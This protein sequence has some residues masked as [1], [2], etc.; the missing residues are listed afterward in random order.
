MG[1]DARDGADAGA[2]ADARAAIA[3]TVALLRDAGV[4]PE[5]RAELV[6]RRLRGVRMVA[7]GELWRLGAL[8]LDADGGIFATGEV[9]VLTRPTHPNH[10]SATALRRNELRRIAQAS[11]MREGTTVVLDA[12]PLD[13]DAPTLPLVAL[14]GGDGG[15]AS[16]ALGVVWTPGAIPTPLGTYLAERAELLA[17]A[18]ARGDAAP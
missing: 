16:G 1:V 11:R 7:R 8:C 3:H 4:A 13:V 12:V 9:L 6:R 2:Y 5:T 15:G 10:R 14:G 17:E 18:A